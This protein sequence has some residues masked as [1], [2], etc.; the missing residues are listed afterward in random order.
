MTGRAPL[1]LCVWLRAGKQG[2]RLEDD[3][4]PAEDTRDIEEIE[5]ETRKADAHNRVRPPPPPPLGRLGAHH[6]QHTAAASC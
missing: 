2:D 5:E 1:R 3:W 6:A 4:V